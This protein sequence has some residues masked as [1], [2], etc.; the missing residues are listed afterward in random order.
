VANFSL[1]KTRTFRAHKPTATKSGDSVVWWITCSIVVSEY[2]KGRH[3]LIITLWDFRFSRRR[4]SW[5]YTD[6]QKC[7][8]PPWFIALMMEAV[9]TPEMSVNF[10]TARRYIPEDDSSTASTHNKDNAIMYSTCHGTCNTAKFT[11]HK[12]RHTVLQKTFPLQFMAFLLNEG[13]KWRCPVWDRSLVDNRWQSLFSFEIWLC[14][15]NVS[16]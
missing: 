1:L 14:D 3:L 6:V 7:V 5:M 12:T 16:L 2:E 4:V 15:L 11:R 13:L 9:R 10:V 8:L